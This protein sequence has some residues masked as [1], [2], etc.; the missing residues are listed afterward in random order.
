MAL[1]VLPV[2]PRQAHRSE[3]LADLRVARAR[4][5]LGVHDLVS[6][7]AAHQVGP[8]RHVEDAQGSRS[9]WL[10]HA[11][12][13]A[14]GTPE[15]S[16]HTKERG[17]SAT[18]GTRHQQVALRSQRQREVAQQHSAIW[19]LNSEVVEAHEGHRRRRR[20]PSANAC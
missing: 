20:I 1:Q 6:Q 4:P 16:E 9:L 19:S 13:A 15:A 5:Q 7:G 3:P 17:L 8:L 14:A 2:L 11:Y 18:I 10:R 12:R